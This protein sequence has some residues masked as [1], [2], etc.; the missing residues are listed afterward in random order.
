MLKE[1]ITK[2]FD[3][4]TYESEYASVS[5]C[6]G[7]L[8]NETDIL[9][10]AND[11]LARKVV[12]LEERIRVLKQVPD[13]YVEQILAEYKTEYSD[14]IHNRAFAEGRMAAYSELGIWR[15]DALE[16]G[17]C[18]VRLSNADDEIVELI[19][20]DLVDVVAEGHERVSRADVLN[21]EIP[22]DDLTDIG[23]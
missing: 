7:T 16:R 6:V 21:G 8:K 10:G 22:I 18:L 12:D 4:Q 11:V 20:D 17:N 1:L 14:R 23:A 5:K 2:L 15:L 13:Q 3:I 9:K 19:A